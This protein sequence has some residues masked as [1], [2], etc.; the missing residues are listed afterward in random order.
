MAVCLMSKHYILLLMQSRMGASG[1]ARA[2]RKTRSVVCKAVV[3]QL[4]L[5]KNNDLCV[6]QFSS[7]YHEDHQRTLNVICLLTNYIHPLLEG[8]I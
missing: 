2:G 6:G 3:T 8:Q 5:I 4:E 1:L 7:G